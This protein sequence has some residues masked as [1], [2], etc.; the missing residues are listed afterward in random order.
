MDAITGFAAP[1]PVTVMCD[2]MALPGDLGEQVGHWTHDIRFLLEPGL[3]N[4]GDLTRVA[5]AVKAFARAL[6]EVVARR[7]L[8]PGDDLVSQLLAVR[9]A[10]GDRLTNEEVAFVCIM[11]FVAGNETTKSL[12]GNGLLALLSHPRQGDRLRQ[13]RPWRKARPARRCAMTA[14]CR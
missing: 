3:M 2:W 13:G 1:L 9:T 11:C 6:A 14:R 4:A 12:I 8:T 5:A 7:R 10:G